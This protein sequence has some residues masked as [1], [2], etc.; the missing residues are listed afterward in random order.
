MANT[1]IR[2]YAKAHNVYLWELAMK[3]HISEP[4]INRKLRTELSAEES[5][6]IMHYIDEIA[7]EKESEV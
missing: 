1:K 5:S 3:M 7:R 4:T 2:S 6:K